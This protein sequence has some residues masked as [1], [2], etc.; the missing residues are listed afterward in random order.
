MARGGL[1]GNSTRF[2]LHPA[3]WRPNDDGIKTKVLIEFETDGSTRHTEGNP[4][5]TVYQLVRSV[6]TIGKTAARDDEPDFRRINEHKQLMVKEG[7]GTWAPHPTGVDVVVEQ[8]LPWGLRDF[9]VMDA[10]EA[11]DFVGGSENKTMHRQDVIDKT[12][13]AVHSLLGIDIFRKASKRVANMAL[14]FGAQAT[15]AIGDADLNALQ[16]EFDQLIAERAELREKISS[17]QTQQTEL[18]DRLRQRRDDL[19]TELK[20]IG[21]AKELRPRLVENRRRHSQ[22][23]KQRKNTLSLLAGE[24][25]STDLLASLASSEIANAYGILRPLYERGS[26]SPQTSQLRAGPPR[27]RNLRLRPEPPRRRRASPPRR[28][29]DRRIRKTGG[30]FQLPR[31]TSRRC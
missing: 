8:L 17:Q 3:W 29:S 20:D 7:D 30:T 27:I 25:E 24:L 28:R 9:F 13:A 16:S 4:T 10:D 1:P 12:T 31:S 19:E 18:K 6:T 5:S 21:A 11:T 2:S 26:H 22:A 23:I 14:A 15:K